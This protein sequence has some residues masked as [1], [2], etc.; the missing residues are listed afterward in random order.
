MAN[1]SSVANLVL[2]LVVVSTNCSKTTFI[3]IAPLQTASATAFVC[4]GDYTIALYIKATSTL[5]FNATGNI[6]QTVVSQAIFGAAGVTVLIDSAIQSA[7]T[8]SLNGLE[9]TLS[10]S[11]ISTVSAN[12]L[13]TYNSRF[14]V[15]NAG[16]VDLNSTFHQLQ[17]LLT[18]G[19]NG[20]SA[21][22]YDIAQS[23]G[24]LTIRISAQDTNLTQLAA[25]IDIVSREGTALTTAVTASIDAVNTQIAT[26]RDKLNN[27]T[28][29]GDADRLE[30]DRTTAAASTAIN[31]MTAAVANIGNYV[32]STYQTA[33]QSAGAVGSSVTAMVFGVIAFVGVLFLLYEWSARRKRDQALD[34]VIRALVA[35][36]RRGPPLQPMGSYGPGPGLQPP[37]YQG[38]QN[39]MPMMQGPMQMQMQM[40]M[41][42][43]PFQQGPQFQQQLQQPL[44]QLQQPQQQQ[45]QLQLPQQS[46]APFAQQSAPLNEKPPLPPAAAPQVPQIMVVPIQMPPAQ[47]SH[48]NHGHSHHTRPDSSGHVLGSP[49]LSGA[50]PPLHTSGGGGGTSRQS[51]QHHHHHPD[52]RTLNPYE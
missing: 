20:S 4:G 44:Q 25:A 7:I 5:C 42:M 16:I 6:N 3:T 39:G 14:T 2:S 32:G 18:G 24:N 26:Y 52:P 17:T 35:Q 8:T 38:Q 49:P 33:M 1:P 21:P 15:V 47:P 19:A 45:M 43:P 13:D 9:S 51:G 31:A 28:L 40:P 29:A 36:A 41:Q 37:P 48:G 12:L 30:L 50:P 22:L 46:A 10:S 27:L 34:V 23:V 11:I